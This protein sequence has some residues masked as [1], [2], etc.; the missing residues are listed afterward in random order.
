M[1]WNKHLLPCEDL[2]FASSQIMQVGRNHII[3]LTSAMEIGLE[4]S[5]GDKLFWFPPQ[6]YLLFTI[7]YKITI[8]YI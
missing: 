4:I 3:S 6:R 1:Y 8:D 5:E 7:I 2:L